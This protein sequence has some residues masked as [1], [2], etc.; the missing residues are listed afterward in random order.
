[1][2]E[3]R[4]R[5]L[6][7]LDVWGMVIGSI[8]GWGSFTLPGQKF[9]PTSGVINT[10]AA[11]FIGGTMMLLIQAAYHKMLQEPIGEGGEFSYVYK[12]VNPRH[13]FIVGWCL[14]LAYLSMVA[15][16]AGAFVK[17][18]QVVWGD[19][20][21]FGYLYS[22]SGSPVYLSHILIM[23]V[24]IGAFC[25]L[26]IRGL[27]A[28]YHVQNVVS[29]L[30][31]F[32]VMILL[33]LVAVKSD[34]QA[35]VD[36]YIVNDAFSF[37]EISTVLAIVPF[38]FV[39][40]D[41]VPQIS[42]ELNFSH[43]RATQITVV[44]IFVG[45]LAY[46]CLNLIAAFSFDRETALQTNWAVADSIIAKIG[47]PGFAAMLVA[48]F[49]AISGG[50]NG[51][52]I[53]SSKV[54]AAMS[55]KKFLHRRY[56]YKNKYA[57]YQNAILFVCAVNLLGPW[58][59]RNLIS[60]LVDMSSVLAGLTYAY[61]SFTAARSERKLVSKAVMYGGFLVSLGFMALLL[62]PG[63]PS[64]LSTVSYVCLLLWLGTGFLFYRRAV[65]IN[66]GS[67]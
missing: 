67:K 36:N 66:A 61:V 15:L 46:A 37:K 33:L 25:L 57:N 55:E 32:I 54:V 39:G 30:L 28:A 2:A 22:V 23:Y 45:V 20:V 10:T 59:G 63:S 41:V 43:K 16:N 48:L 65:K 9:L 50:I 8:I 12:H 44:S 1:M 26:N 52:M 40:F 60:Y 34:R 51:F 49:A 42:T 18:F 3:R 27:K 58:L 4:A 62:I 56:F 47:Y 17:L 53:S 24:V 11:L 14:S 5:E 7:K 13:G 64:Q 38:L 35:F 19:K 29:A 6:N 31:V 21:D